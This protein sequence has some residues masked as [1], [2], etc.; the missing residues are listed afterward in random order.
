MLRNL[1]RAAMYINFKL[2]STPHNRPTF[3]GAVTLESWH[4]LAP[5]GRASEYLGL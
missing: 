2:G 1:A 4:H 5:G 3:F